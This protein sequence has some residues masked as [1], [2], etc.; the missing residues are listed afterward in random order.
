MQIIEIQCCT[1][2]LPL[3]YNHNS[4]RLI[5]QELTSHITLILYFIYELFGL[6]EI[7]YETTMQCNAIQTGDTR[8]KG[9]KMCTQAPALGTLIM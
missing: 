7:S 4:S 2:Y 8:Y 3:T 9:A 1:T 6:C 5:D